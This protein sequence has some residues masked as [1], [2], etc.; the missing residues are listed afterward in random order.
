[1]PEGPAA[2]RITVDPHQQQEPDWN[3]VYFLQ[4]FEGLASEAVSVDDIRQRTRAAWA[5]DRQQRIE[6][7][8]A[9]EAEDI[10]Q[11]EER[12]RLQQEEDRLNEEEVRKRAEEARNASGRKES[13]QPRTF[14]PLAANQM[15]AKDSEPVASNYAVHKT[16]AFDYVELWYWTKEGCD[17][18]RVTNIST[19]PDALT[20]AKI[21]NQVVLKPSNVSRPSRKVV[22]DGQLLWSQISVG[23]SGLLKQMAKSGWPQQ[24][25]ASLGAFYLELE[26]HAIR[27]EVMG[28]QAVIAYADEV[29]REWFSAIK[30]NSPKVAFNIGIINE[31]RLDKIHCRLL[32]QQQGRSIEL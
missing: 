30:P 9:Q 28:E 21:D 11:E 15:V 17:E 27:H 32:N 6:A 10:R 24:Y 5:A 25:I 19:D 23:K 4:V 12:Q 1:M 3:A 2:P 16:E 26:S 8:D 7:W 13:R 18:A 31:D 22:P 29:R 20:L 14:K